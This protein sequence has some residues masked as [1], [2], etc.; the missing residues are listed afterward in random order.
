MAGGGGR[1]AVKTTL[2]PPPAALR[3]R[4]RFPLVSAA[5]ERLSSASQRPES[6]RRPA[7]DL[8][9]GGHSAGG[10]RRGTLGGKNEFDAPAGC[11]AMPPPFSPC[12]CG[13]RAAFTRDTMGVCNAGESHRV[14]LFTR[15]LLAI[16]THALA[17][18]MFWG[19]QPERA[20]AM[21]ERFLNGD[22]L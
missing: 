3:C 9:G 16:V 10:W 5:L 6:R 13:P 12:F 1:W 20:L 22:E 4:P 8:Q 19:T 15:A 2:T 11:P 7:P 21:F 18:H 17:G 14:L